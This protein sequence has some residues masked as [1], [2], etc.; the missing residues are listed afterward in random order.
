VKLRALLRLVGVL[1]AVIGYFI[2]A[3]FLIDAGFEW[4]GLAHGQTLPATPNAALTPGAI[5]DTDPAVICAP[6]YARGHR[7]WHDKRSTLLKYG[8]APANARQ[9]EDDDLVPVCLG[10]NNADPRNHWTQPI[11]EAREKDEKLEW[12]ICRAI[13]SGDYLQRGQALLDA[14]H[15]FLSGQWAQAL[16]LKELTQ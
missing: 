4:W 3:K 8:I 7:V 1:A 5:L 6:G 14:Q 13:C 12:P 2:L 10:G 15:F 16:H 11:A 9:Y